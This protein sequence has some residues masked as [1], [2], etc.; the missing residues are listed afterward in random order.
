MIISM[1]YFWFSF[2]CLLVRDFAV[3]VAAI[4]AAVADDVVVVVCLFV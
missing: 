3:A 1:R 2:F 4:V